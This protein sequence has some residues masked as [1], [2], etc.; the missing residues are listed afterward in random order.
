[1]KALLGKK[2]GMTQV[3]DAD[4][5]PTVVT[6][7]VAG[8]CFVT[9]I[10]TDAKEK[11]NAVQI[12]FGEKKKL[13][14]AMLGHLKGQLFRYLEEFP[15]E[16]EGLKVGAKLDVSQFEV[17]QKV[18][19]SGVSRGMGFAGTI[20]R[21]NFSQAPR[22]HGHPFCRKPGSIGSMYPERVFPGLRMA[23]RMGSD[24]ITRITKVIGVDL[25][26]NLLL[27]KGPVPG[28]KENYLEIV[29]VE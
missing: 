25:E 4:G 11:Y 15:I 2:I 8:P 23:G 19:I 22:S 1:M 14:K 3:F 16:Q 10:K 27:V 13:N 6:V 29:G 18:T 17:G 7:L 28:K 21:H 20:K 5:K 24:R 9:Q 26:K 12:G